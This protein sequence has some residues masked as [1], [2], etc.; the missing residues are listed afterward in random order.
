MINVKFIEVVNFSEHFV[1]LGTEV[2]SVML[3]LSLEKKVF[4]KMMQE[5]V[6]ENLGRVF[7]HTS[8]LLC[9]HDIRRRAGKN[10][11]GKIQANLLSSSVKIHHDK[12]KS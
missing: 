6:A 1:T 3:R 10:L 4:C 9:S 7:S 8:S 12:L 2:F 11:N 5:I